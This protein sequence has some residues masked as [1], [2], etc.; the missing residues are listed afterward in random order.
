[1]LILASASNAVNAP[2]VGITR[3]H[4]HGLCE[5]ICKDQRVIDMWGAS[6]AQDT[7]SQWKSAAA[8]D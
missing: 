8:G 2:M 7:L 6:G 1:M 3:E 4:Y 5:A